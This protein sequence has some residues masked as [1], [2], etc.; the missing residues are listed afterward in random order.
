MSCLLTLYPVAFQIGMD[1]CMQLELTQD[2]VASSLSGVIS[3]SI[4][5]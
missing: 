1:T 3:I 4:T 2:V 5:Q